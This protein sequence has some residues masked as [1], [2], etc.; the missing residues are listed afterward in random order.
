MCSWQGSEQAVAIGSFLQ[1]T[2][3]CQKQDFVYFCHSNRQTGKKNGTECEVQSYAQED[4]KYSKDGTLE[5]W[6]TMNW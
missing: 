6:G 2:H 4:L 1:F 5:Q 3:E